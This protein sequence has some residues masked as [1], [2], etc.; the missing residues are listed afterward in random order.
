MKREIMRV[1]VVM[2][3][4]VDPALYSG[5]STPAERAEIDRKNFEEDPDGLRELLENKEVSKSVR[6]TAV[7]IE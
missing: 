2:E 3:Y 7:I 4:P 6:V 1:T 5:A